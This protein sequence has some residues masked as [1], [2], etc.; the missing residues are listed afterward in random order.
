MHETRWSRLKRSIGPNA[1]LPLALWMLL[2]VLACAPESKEYAVSGE[3]DG[4]LQDGAG[5]VVKHDEIP[6]YMPA[7]TMKFEV[8][9]P[10]RSPEL[11]IGDA[12]GFTLVNEGSASYIRNI[13]K[14]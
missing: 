3:I 14:R 5:L 8:E 6:G 9:D 13:E 10:T 1:A 11:T 2:V 12:V 4:V 7:M